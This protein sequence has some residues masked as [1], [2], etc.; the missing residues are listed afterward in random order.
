MYLLMNKN[1]IVATI[2]KKPKS[3][4]S[5]STSF[6]ITEIFGNLPYGFSTVDAWLNGRKAS[7]HN[8]HLVEI[9]KNLNCYD[10]EGFMRV[11]HA[12]TINDTFWVKSDTERLSWEQISL[13]R[14]QF[15]ETISRLAFEGVGLYDVVFSSLSPE[16]ACEGSFKK[17]FRKEDEKGEWGSDIFIYKRGSEGFSNAG[18]EPYCEVLSSE[19]AQIICPDAVSYELTTLHE[20]LASR[21]NLFTNEENGYVPFAKLVDV[22]KMSFEDMFRYFIEH[23]AE[24]KFREMLV[25]DALCF[26]E[27]RHAGN[28]GMLFNNDTLEVTKMSPVFDL[29]LS[30]L[31]YAHDKDLINIGDS[32]YARSPKLGEDFTRMGQVA[33]NEIIRDR[34]KDVRDFSFSFRGDDTFSPER[35]CILE[36]AVRRQAEAILSSQKLMTKDVFISGNAIAQE[37]LKQKSNKAIVLVNEFEE[38]MRQPLENK[39]CFISVCMNTGNAQCLIEDENGSFEMAID[40]LKGSLEMKSNGKTVAPQELKETSPDTYS[41]YDEVK[42]SLKM[43]MREKQDERFKKFF[44]EYE[45]V[46]PN[47]PFIP[48]GKGD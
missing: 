35:V 42:K 21:C 40:F 9:M 37:E 32:L 29:N 14:N 44:K 11:T 16:L 28:F 4:F 15:T 7:N 19:I 3:E 46:Q 18:L 30:L 24:Q 1:N 41:I 13:Y 33:C 34:V 45:S 2:D 38:R 5:V 12:A 17:C 26:N 31:V 22:K 20:K 6:E 27:D 8:K 23:G 48:S 36:Q 47:D 39:E 10:N 25:L 43:Y